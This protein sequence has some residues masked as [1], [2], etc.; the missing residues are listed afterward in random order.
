MRF[1]SGFGFKNEAPLFTD[2]LPIDDAPFCAAGFSLGAIRAYQ[3]VAD[4]SQRFDRLILLSPSFFQDR[5]DRFIR[6]Q[7]IGFTRDRDSYMQNFY[8]N[9]GDLDL[10]YKKSDAQKS[11]LEFLLNFH[12]K[13]EDFKRLSKVKI[14]VILGAND[15][16]INANMAYE[17]FRAER[18]ETRYIKNANHLLRNDIK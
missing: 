11:D 18:I 9:C 1:F 6:S 8:T 13:A 14:E 3:F 12:W 4:R 10:K 15:K 2:Y 5:E 17:F 16:I 7:L